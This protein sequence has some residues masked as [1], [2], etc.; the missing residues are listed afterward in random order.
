MHARVAWEVRRQAGSAGVSSARGTKQGDR[1]A[2]TLR[3]RTAWSEVKMPERAVGWGS[4]FFRIGICKLLTR[5]SFYLCFRLFLRVPPQTPLIPHDTYKKTNKQ[6]APHTRT[7]RA[8]FFT[9]FP[10]DHSRILLRELERH[11]ARSGERSR[12]C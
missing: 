7:P 8:P 10:A 9:F 2:V 11:V 6:E 1:L 3:I 5:A 4:S 12:A